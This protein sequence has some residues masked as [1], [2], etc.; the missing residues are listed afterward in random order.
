[1]GVVR[2]PTRRNFGL[3]WIA[4]STAGYAAAFAAWTAGSRPI[5]PVL[6]GIL[7]GSLTLAL[8]GGTVGACAGLAQA[9]VLRQRLAQ[10]S[11]WIAA[12]AAGC[13]VGLVAAAWLGLV[14]GRAMSS[15][16]ASLGLL[17]GANMAVARWL[18]LTLAVNLTFSLL[19]GASV[20]AARWLVVSGSGTADARWIPASMV[21]FTVGYGTALLISPL[22]QPLPVLLQGALFGACTGALTALV[23]WLWLRRQPKAWPVAGPPHAA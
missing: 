1:M 15:A 14:V 23:E 22:A 6:S 16:I 19:I 13:A 9:F 11:Q 8:V 17:A 7:G 5:W 10:A 3:G 4:A 21:S 2:L 12:S 18:V 20:G